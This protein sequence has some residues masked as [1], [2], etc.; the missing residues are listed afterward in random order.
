MAVW[1]ISAQEGTGGARIAAAL[2]VAADVS[3]VDRE[4][5]ALLAH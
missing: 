4:T 5:L 3:L 1:T 2:A